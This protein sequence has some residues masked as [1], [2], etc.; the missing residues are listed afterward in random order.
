MR[1]DAYIGDPVFRIVTS[2]DSLGLPSDM[3]V[4]ALSVIPKG[5]DYTLLLPETVDGAKS[6]GI[7]PVTYEVAFAWMRYLL[8]PDRPVDPA[9]ARYVICFACDTAPWDHRTSWLWK[10]DQGESIGRV[11]T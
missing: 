4:E 1:F 9:H 6:Y 2:G 11:R 7:A 10:N 8:L 5:S 3:Q